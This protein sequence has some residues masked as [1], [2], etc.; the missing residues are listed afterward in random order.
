MFNRVNLIYFV[1]ALVLFLV[2]FFIFL[3]KDE[4]IKN[5]PSSGVDIIAFGD[6]LI[7]G[8]GASSEDKNLTSLLSRKIGRPIINL[9][10]SGNTTGDGLARLSVFDKYKPKVVILLLG[11][12]DYLKKIPQKETFSNLEKI[13]SDLQ[14][15][16]AVV[17]LLGIKGSVLGDK[18]ESSFE[19]LSEK[20]GTAYVS[21]VLSGLVANPQYMSDAIHPNDLGYQ[22]MA[23]RI[24]PELLKVLR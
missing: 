13:I 24:Y 16:G 22:K 15:R 10:V 19:E 7:E 11:G 21:N 1:I 8:V 4:K 6:S 2:L 9:G 14:K 12:N 3:N 5:Y 23:D 20:Y 18:F 17:L